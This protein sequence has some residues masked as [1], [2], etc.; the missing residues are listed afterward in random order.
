MRVLLVHQN[1][2]GQFRHLVSGLTGRLGWDVVGVGGEKAPGLPDVKMYRYKLHRQVAGQQHPY[3]R[4]MESA[5]LHGQAVARLLLGLKKEGFAPDVVL[6]HPGWG[7]TLFIRDIFPDIRVVHYCEWYYGIKGSDSGFDPEFPVTLDG[8]ARVRAWN[9][10]HLLNLETCDSG[11]SPTSWQKNQHPRLYQDKI[12]VIHEGINTDNLAPDHGVAFAAPSGAVFR[13]GDPVIT[14]VSRNLEPYRGFHIFMRALEIV[15]RKHGACQALIVGGGGVSY[16]RPPE[17]AANWREKM[18][19]EVR[20]DPAR[21]HFVGK[22]PY[23]VYRRILQV[24]LVHVY[25][26][27]PFVL[28][29][30]MLEAMC[31]GCLVVGSRTAPVE[32]V[33]RDGENGLLADFFD[34]EGIADRIL[35]VLDSPERFAAMRERARKDACERFTLRAGLEGYQAALENAFS[36]KA[37]NQEIK[38]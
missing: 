11:V 30:S 22:V 13:F 21:T 17:G 38:Q 27:Y 36:R 18:L 14:Y 9:A 3:L 31:S 35:E 2:P 7:E 20:L 5:V 25:L 4:Q 23:D 16:G 28:S 32:E 12:S 26:T 10:L 19:E 34:V 33:I 1:F 24:S 37:G 8:S 29:W 15:Q 6:A